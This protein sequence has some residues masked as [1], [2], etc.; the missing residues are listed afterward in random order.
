MGLISFLLRI[1]SIKSVEIIR[2]LISNKI[3]KYQ[4]QKHSNYMLISYYQPLSKDKEAFLKIIS[5]K[6]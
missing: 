5:N 1:Y 3:I 4:H 2:R 6:N